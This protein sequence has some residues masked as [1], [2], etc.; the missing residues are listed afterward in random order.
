MFSFSRF[1]VFL[2][3]LAI[4]NSS[5]AI[6]VIQTSNQVEA[7]QHSFDYSTSSDRSI[8]ISTAFVSDMPESSPFRFELVPTESTGWLW[9]YR[10]EGES[11]YTGNSEMLV[12]SSG[13]LPIPPITYVGSEPQPQSAAAP[14]P[15]PSTLIVFG[16]GLLALSLL[17]G[18]K[19]KTKSSS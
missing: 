8:D 17:V 14:V 2:L 4:A 11:D 9:I 6:P 12:S 1:L 3:A 16:V 19:L 7:E 10:I 15:E 18:R 5:N 13:L